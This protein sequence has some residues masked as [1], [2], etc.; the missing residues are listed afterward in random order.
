MARQIPLQQIKITENRIKLL[1]EMGI[2]SLRDLVLHF[3]YRYECIEETPLI[4]N[5][6]V[7]IEGVLIEEPKVFFKG[8]L[9]RLTFSLLYQ[10][11][12]YKITIFN[13]HFMKKNM[14]KGMI[15]TVIGKY[16]SANNSIVASDIKLKALNEIAGITPVY[17]LKEGITQK[18]F[19]NY[20]KKA[21][22]F[23]Q[24]HIQD[25]IPN[26]L[27]IKHH[28]IHKELALNLIHFPANNNDIK[29]ASRHLKYEEFLKF[30]LTMQYIK[31]SRK[32]NIGVKKN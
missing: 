29:E 22:K 24:G 10:Q 27:L 13:R 31:I 3:P 19:Q 7:I 30:Q 5:E 32:K 8:R 16:N 25:E 28:L 26:S 20:V 2:N 9:S 15:L 4:N 1:N 23:Y 18:S 14:T 12:I 21:L 11:E 17:S 6:K